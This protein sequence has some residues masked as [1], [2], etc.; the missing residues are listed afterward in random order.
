MMPKVSVIVPCYNVAEYLP[1]CIDSIINQT[2]HDIQLI[3]VDDGSPDQSGEICDFAAKNDPRIKVLHKVNEGVSK[4][5][6]DG[7][8]LA[9]GEFV[10][11]VDSDDYLCHKALELLY[12]EAVSTGSDMV[13][14]DVYRVFDEKIEYCKFYSDPFVLTERERIN[15]L[16]KADLYKNYCPSPPANGPAFGYGGPW[17]K[18]VR[19]KM[20]IDNDIL[21]D[22][23]LKGVFDDILYSAYILSKSNRVSYIQE[24]VYYYRILGNSITATYKKN[25]PG[26]NEAILHA[27]SNF[28]DQE[29]LWGC[30]GSAYG[31]LTLRRITESLS[32]YYFNEKHY[33]NKKQVTK[34]IKNT[35]GQPLFKKGMQLIDYKRLTRRHKAIY[36]ICRLRAYSMLRYLS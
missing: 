17:N 32:K 7:F 27:F 9:T 15:E 35:L 18:L 2:L 21:F 4:A 24:P 31:A 36:M 33:E 29:K 30:C 26:I 25:M 6:N 10:I 20:L 28:L 11:F 8:K 3:L 16:I 1:Q 22:S 5:R 19:R 12:D 34:E 13:I 14:G 23:S